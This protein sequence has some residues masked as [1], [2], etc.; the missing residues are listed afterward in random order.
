MSAANSEYRPPSD[1][2]S[3]P[4]ERRRY[5]VLAVLWLATFLFWMGWFMQGPLLVSYWGIQEHVS[6]GS[7]EYLLSAVSIVGIVTSIVAGH[8]YDRF[9]TR[10]ATALCFTFITIGF[11]LRPFTA[12]NF[13]ATMTLTIV[14]GIGL[15]LLVAPASIAAQWFG[16]HRMNF[17]L[18]V[19]YSAVALG[20]TAGSLLGARMRED[21]GISW[22]FGVMSIALAATLILWWLLVPERPKEP[23]GPPAT[24]PAPLLTALREVVRA[25][26][27]WVF[28]GVAA[29][30]SGAVVFSGSYLSGFLDATYRLSPVQGGNDSAVFAGAS[31]IGMLV[32]G[33]LARRSRTT[34]EFGLGTAA[35]WLLAWLAITL[36]WLAGGL[37]LWAELIFL[38]VAGFSQGPSYNFGVNA[39]EHGRG[40]RPETIGVAAGFYFTGSS[41]GGYVFPTIIARIVDALHT[42]AGLVGPLVLLVAATGLWAVS[43]FPQRR[44]R[45]TTVIAQEATV[46]R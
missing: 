43:Y 22:A 41:I 37:P 3:Y 31:F 29:V 1:P 18:A 32:M 25:E 11:G 27:A 6:F 12:D 17:P 14:A 10:K 13:A 40:I 26:K 38:A 24:A 4:L 7:A 30:S 42:G 19:G 33:Y 9:G 5:V 2:D 8:A 44:A 34:R 28:F 35:V 21:L 39:L 23:A 16:R 36:A 45:R 15:P 20:Q 46:S